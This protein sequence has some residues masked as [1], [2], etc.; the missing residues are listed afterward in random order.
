MKELYYNYI[1]YKWYYFIVNDF[2]E[3]MII[4]YIYI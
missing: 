3:Y 4:L 1:Y 2:V